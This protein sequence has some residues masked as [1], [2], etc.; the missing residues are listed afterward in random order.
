MTGAG[1]V[2][3][4]QVLVDAQPGEEIG[5][6]RCPVQLLHRRKAVVDEARLRRMTGLAAPAPPPMAGE[7][8]RRTI[9]E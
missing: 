5:D 6:N 1:R 7:S 2:G 8:A 3:P 9:A 4:C